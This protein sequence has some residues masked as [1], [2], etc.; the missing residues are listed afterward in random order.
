MK[1]CV[2]CGRVCGVHPEKLA[3]VGEESLLGKT[4]FCCK[5]PQLNRNLRGH[6]VLVKRVWNTNYIKHTRT[7]FA[8]AIINKAR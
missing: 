5:N 8:D 4:L 1:T 3:I 7:P 6:T 2:N